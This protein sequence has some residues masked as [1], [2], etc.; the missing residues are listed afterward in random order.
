MVLGG[1]NPLEEGAI[2]I[3]VEGS[4]EAMT[5]ELTNTRV[6]STVVGIDPITEP[7]TKHELPGSL[8]RIKSKIGDRKTWSGEASFGKCAG[9]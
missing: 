6:A 4:R 8:S 1:S 9:N 2:P 3:L 5:R 7:T